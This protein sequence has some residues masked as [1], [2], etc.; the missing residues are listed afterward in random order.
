MPAEAYEIILR[1][2]HTHTV[3]NCCNFLFLT[4][5]NK[6]HTMLHVTAQKMTLQIFG[7]KEVTN[8]LLA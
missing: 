7:D 8:R 5:L 2:E 1:S 4:N 6:K 3:N